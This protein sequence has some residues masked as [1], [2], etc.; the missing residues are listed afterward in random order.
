MSSE[1]MDLSALCYRI[2]KI[3]PLFVK[4]PDKLQH[5]LFYGP[6]GSG[7]T[8]SATKLLN[9]V[10]EG[11]PIRPQVCR[12][13]NAADERSLDAIRSKILPFLEVDWR[14][15][16]DLRPRFLV[17]DECETLTESAQLALRPFLDMRPQ[18]VCIIFICNSLS[19]LHESL[20]SRFLRIRFDPP[21]T[22]KNKSLLL[23]Y[24][25]RGDLRQ[26]RNN[27]NNF[28]DIITLF[29]GED[30]S[31]GL[32]TTEDTIL[33]QLLYLL[34]YLNMLD[35][36]IYNQLSEFFIAGVFSIH[37]ELYFVS[38]ISKIINNMIKKLDD[39]EG[40]LKWSSIYI[41]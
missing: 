25:L 34:N 19:R 1:D 38:T 7:K 10:W 11:S 29:N 27:M 36:N 6:P 37:N 16:T 13:L 15:K 9:K 17:L 28:R 26:F 8:T 41:K 35:K 39:E 40:G 4:H 5:L 2:Q 12:I 30:I 24:S 23:H 31:N 3:I 22:P 20:R 33:T 32:T 21:P 14:D 18:D